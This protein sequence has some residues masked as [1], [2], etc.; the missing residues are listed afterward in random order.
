MYKTHGGSYTREYKVW[1]D[2]LRRCRKE[3]HPDY[4]DY[5]GRGITVCERWLNFAKFIADMGARPSDSHSL[6]RKNNDGNYEPSNYRWAT[7]LQ[8]NN[9]T[10]SNRYITFNGRTLTIAEWSAEFNINQQTLFARISVYGWTIER[11]LTQ[12]VD[13][14]KDWRATR[15]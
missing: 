5:G 1:G 6:D 7:E 3:N 13:H 4:K 15:P 8:Q 14:S 2:M 11:A 10:R 9:N 12:P